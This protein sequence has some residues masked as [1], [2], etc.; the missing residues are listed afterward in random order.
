M[1]AKRKKD[2][3]QKLLEEEKKIER[4]EAKLAK[5]VKAIKKAEE[6]IEKREIEIE[7]LEKEVLFKI[8]SLKVR[9]KHIFDNTKIVAGAL[10]GTGLGRAIESS[11]GFAETLPLTNI[12]A[13]VGISLILAALLT[14]KTEKKEILSSKTPMKYILGRVAHI[15]LV[16]ILVVALSS[17]LFVTEFPEPVLFLK[18]LLIS[19]FSAVSGAITFSLF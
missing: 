1:A 9:K 17:L 19:S 10:L 11:R 16:A 8:G 15:Y 5:E 2:V 3:Q 7:K 13:I 18:V 14:F 12:L 6:N 4:E